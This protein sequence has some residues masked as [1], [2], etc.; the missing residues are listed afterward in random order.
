[1]GTISSY[2]V[3]LEILNFGLESWVKVKS[4]RKK[5]T[6][7]TISQMKAP[8]RTLDN[9]MLK[10]TY[11]APKKGALEFGYFQLLVTY[12]YSNNGWSKTDGG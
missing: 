10:A 4:K 8:F 1:M 3:P 2:R 9:V 7:H 5:W 6:H 12:S 11:I